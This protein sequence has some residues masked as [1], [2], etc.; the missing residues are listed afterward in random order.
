MNDKLAT[1]PKSG[2]YIDEIMSLKKACELIQIL[3]IFECITYRI[4]PSR[5][6]VVVSL[7]LP[8]VSTC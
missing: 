5:E 6:H 3:G 2:M 8:V 4:E 1:E 7:D